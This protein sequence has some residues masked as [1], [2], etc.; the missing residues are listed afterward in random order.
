[1]K[2][3]KNY[4]EYNKP[5]KKFYEK[6]RYISRIP[7]KT[8]TKLLL[9]PRPPFANFM[10]VEDYLMSIYSEGVETIVVFLQHNEERGLIDEYKR[11]GFKVIHFPMRDFSIPDNMYELSD[12]LHQIRKELKSNGVAM[13]CFG[14]NGRTGTVAASLL[15]QMGMD[16]QKA[17]DF[18][19]KYRP[20]AIETSA[21]EKFVH[22]FYFF[23]KFVK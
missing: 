1:M 6:V 17:I 20:E 2:R 23:E 16:P 18:I 8:G 4:T 19:R 12:T 22:D 13:H 15:V 7:F 3:I 10:S 9:T 21:Q 14:G 11:A 5:F